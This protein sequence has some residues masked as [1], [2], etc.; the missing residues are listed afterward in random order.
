MALGLAVGEDAQAGLATVSPTLLGERHQPG[1]RG[2]VSNLDPSNLGLGAV[3]R[4]LCKGVVSNLLDM[5]PREVFVR[6]GVRRIVG[7]GSALARNALLQAEVRNA[8]QMPV[9]FTQSGD[10]A[11][12]AALAASFQHPDL[13]PLRRSP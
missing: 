9:H 6:H 1:L 4:A 3:F 10:A 2:V 5:M 13:R 8:Y 7:G 11:V 12:G